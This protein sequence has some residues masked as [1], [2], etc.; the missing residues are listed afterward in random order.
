MLRLQRKRKDW[1]FK[2]PLLGFSMLLQRCSPGHMAHFV[3]LSSLDF[4]NRPLPQG[5]GWYHSNS[6]IERIRPC[7]NREVE[8]LNCPRRIGNKVNAKVCRWNRHPQYQRSSHRRKHS[9]KKKNEYIGQRRG[10]FPLRLGVKT[11]PVQY[12][13]CSGC[14]LHSLRSPVFTTYLG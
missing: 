12:Q 5:E 6:R 1:K 14:A 3:E 2:A 11:S 10:L 13:T 4:Y 7:S 9:G 8:I